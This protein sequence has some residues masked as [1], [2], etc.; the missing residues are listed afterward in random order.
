ML[1]KSI[2][3]PVLE[4]NKENT[5]RMMG[6]KGSNRCKIDNSQ[7]D[8]PQCFFLKNQTKEQIAEGMLSFGER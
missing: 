1:R 2:Y 4:I 7:I 6:G 3:L 5:V 8:F